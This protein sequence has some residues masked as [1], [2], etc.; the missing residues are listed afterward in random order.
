MTSH[1]RGANRTYLAARLCSSTGER[2][3]KYSVSLMDELML[4]NPRTG[5][6]V[7]GRGTPGGVRGCEVMALLPL[8]KA[9]TA[10]G[11]VDTSAD[12]NTAPRSTPQSERVADASQVWDWNISA[13]SWFPFGGM[14]TQGDADPHA[15]MWWGYPYDD[16]QPPLQLPLGSG[17]SLDPPWIPP[18]DSPDQQEDCDSDSSSDSFSKCIVDSLEAFYWGEE[19]H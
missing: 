9:A 5:T 15:G 10:T 18:A 12:T 3:Q 1:I 2:C 16:V 6:V 7:R 14:W 4:A 11:N 8:Q 13:A 17:P 19:F